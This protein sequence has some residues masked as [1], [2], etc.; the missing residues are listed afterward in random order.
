MLPVPVQ[1][2]QAGLDSLAEGRG[3][4]QLVDWPDV[5][6]GQLL[7]EMGRRAP[8]LLPELDRLTLD[9]GYVAGDSTS[10]WSFEVAWQPGTKVLDNG[11]VRSWSDAPP[12][13]RMVSVELL[14]DVVVRGE[15]VARM[16]VA[17]DSMA[18]RPA[19]NGYRFDV[20][21]GH[22]RVFL[23]TDPDEAREFLKS[24]A[25]LDN[26]VVERM[27]FAAFGRPQT[28]DARV[29]R[30]TPR[31]ERVPQPSI[32]EPR[33]SILIG[34]RIGP[35]PYYV[36]TRRV[37]GGRDDARRR[38][39]VQGRD[40]TGTADARPRRGEDVDREEAAREQDDDA[41]ESGRRSGRRDGEE[42]TADRGDRS[43]R[44]G[45]ESSK[46]GTSGKRSGDDDDDDDE[47][48]LAVPALGA[49]AAVGL[50][51]YAGGTVGVSG[52]GDSPIGL[53]AGYTH[54]SGGIQ[55]QAS[56]NPAVIAQE[57][58]QKLTVKALGF[59]DVFASR[60]QPA[61]GLGIQADTG[62]ADD[63]EPAVSAG[64]VGNLGRFVLYGGYDIAQNTP[65]VGLAYNFRY[66]SP[67]KDDDAI[68]ER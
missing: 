67:E 57:E 31:Q 15:Q 4:V 39:D 44:S 49:A 58:N 32:Y 27:G 53:A 21:V 59:Y 38:P 64:L 48:S 1:A 54:R 42:A 14:A 10:D 35:N 7:D 8:R 37:D 12:D 13:V 55:L 24:G 20:R 23:D 62:S 30:E 66:R 60:I 17:V 11:R 28:G 63:I 52:T 6:L 5:P 45:D 36:G 51:A 46:R 2:Q 68:A 56:V 33:T 19:P 9:Y 43:G 25:T 22:D 40:A 16:I 47:P 50:A 41:E 29:P 26:L 34:W 61:I 18:L 3:T 65:E